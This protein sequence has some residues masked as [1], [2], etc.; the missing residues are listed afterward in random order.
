MSTTTNDKVSTGPVPPRPKIIPEWTDDERRCERPGYIPHPTPS[1]ANHGDWE[2]AYFPQLMV[3]YNIVA[4]TIEEK[5][6][7]NR[8]KWTDNQE[9]FDNISELLYKSS[10]KY[11][12]PYLESEDESESKELEEE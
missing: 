5:Y 11:I 6:P 3:M 12:S 1:D 7:R 8:I 9:L 10:S 4:G 2:H